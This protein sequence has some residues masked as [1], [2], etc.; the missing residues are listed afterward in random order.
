VESKVKILVVET[1]VHALKRWPNAL[2]AREETLLDS[3]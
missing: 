2:E 1:A 3:I